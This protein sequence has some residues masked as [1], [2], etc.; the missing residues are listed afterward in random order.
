MGIRLPECALPVLSV[1]ILPHYTV[2]SLSVASYANTCTH[3]MTAVMTITMVTF[4][5]TFIVCTHYKN[6]K[7]EAL[8]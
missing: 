2:P 1:H 5:N 8:A 3:V 7:L 4:A 6:R